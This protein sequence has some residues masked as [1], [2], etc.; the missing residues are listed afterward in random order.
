MRLAVL[1]LLAF[2]LP[3]AALADVKEPE[4]AKIE[5]MAKRLIAERRLAYLSDAIDSDH[6]VHMWFVNGKTGMWVQ[7]KVGHDLMACIE[8][9]GYDWHYA[10]G[11]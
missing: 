5:V 7:I 1:T 6:N 2:L 10:A 9:E 3:A 11:G 8:M 4:C